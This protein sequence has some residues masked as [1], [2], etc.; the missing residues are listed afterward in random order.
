MEDREYKNYLIRQRILSAIRQNLKE[1][2]MVDLTSRQLETLLLI[3]D[4]T[5]IKRPTTRDEIAKKL[6]LDRA[7]ISNYIKYLSNITPPLVADKPAI[8]NNDS[9]NIYLTPHGMTL[10]RRVRG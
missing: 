6:N 3:G 9:K 5:K 2:Y 7:N 10:Y 4:K 8:A 1:E